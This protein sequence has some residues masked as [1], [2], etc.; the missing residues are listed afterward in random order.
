MITGE[1]CVEFGLQPKNCREPLFTCDQLVEVLESQG[2]Y[3][4]CS[5]VLRG[6]V[7]HAKI[8]ANGECYVEG[9]FGRSGS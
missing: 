5:Q 7:V 8:V 3:V 6:C 2:I 9:R 4:R 1:A